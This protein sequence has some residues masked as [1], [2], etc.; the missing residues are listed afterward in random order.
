MEYSSAAHRRRERKEKKECDAPMT[1]SRNLSRSCAGKGSFSTHGVSAP[2][3]LTS[4]E[5]RPPWRQHPSMLTR[6]GCGAGRTKN[7]K[8]TREVSEGRTRGERMREERVCASP[9]RQCAKSAGEVGG[10]EGEGE[11]ER[12][13]E[14]A[15][16][17]RRRERS[18]GGK[19]G[20]QHRSLVTR[21]TCLKRL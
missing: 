19:A 12:E 8:M 2:D 21:R 13:R 11:G 7:V 17:E 20:K 15:T 18:R 5:L 10:G 4:R 3:S 6:W 9:Y 14:R 1:S 16:G